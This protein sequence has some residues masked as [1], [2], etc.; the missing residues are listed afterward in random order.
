MPSSTYSEMMWTV[1]L[2]L[3][4][5]YV[6]CGN[7]TPVSLAS[8]GRTK[9][10]HF[11]NYNKAKKDNKTW[12]RLLGSQRVSI[13]RPPNDS[14]PVKEEEELTSFMEEARQ[15]GLLDDDRLDVFIDE[16]VDRAR[17][18]RI[19]DARVARDV[20]WVVGAHVRRGRLPSLRRASERIRP[21]QEAWLAAMRNLQ[22]VHTNTGEWA[23]N[24]WARLRVACRSASRRYKRRRL[25]NEMVEVV[26]DV[27][28]RACAG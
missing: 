23:W 17:E 24:W 20:V 19:R 7:S 1:W 22:N 16:F 4:S 26:E 27:A 14:S 10:L 9:V 21:I 15:P 3:C 13:W 18:L 8:S 12:S 11:V 28:R 25:L 5:A 6:W 2:V